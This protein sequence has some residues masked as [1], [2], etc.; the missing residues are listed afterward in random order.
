ME[1]IRLDSVRLIATDDTSK[2]I[3]ERLR[4]E[5][6]YGKEDTE[7]QLINM[8]FV[9]SAEGVENIPNM[10]SEDTPAK[11]NVIITINSS[12]QID[13]N[14]NYNSILS[15][16]DGA[17]IYTEI[18]T[19]LYLIRINVEIHGLVCFDFNDFFVLAKGRNRIS[20]VSYPYKDNIEE[21]INEIQK[22]KLQDD[23]KCLLFFTIEHYD[24]N[25]FEFDM[26][27]VKNY[28]DTFPEKAT[29]YWNLAESTDKQVTLFTSSSI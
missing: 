25:G 8:V 15:F 12:L 13:D 29:L 10:L 26:L 16:L 18:K 7:W 27:P 22:I 9:A 21:A 28:L 19:L 4:S 23:S 20:T 6:V 17:D 3:I 1:D 2:E 5:G 11:R 24:R 14:A